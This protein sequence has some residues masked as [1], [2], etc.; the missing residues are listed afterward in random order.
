MD[1]ITNSLGIIPARFAS[2]RFPGKPLVD[3]GGKTMVQRVYEQACQ[4]VLGQVVVATD[5]Q[6]IFDHVASFGGQ[7]VMTSD[8]HPSGTDR[9]AE[10]AALPQYADFQFVVNVQ[11][12]EP[13]LSPAQI[14]LVLEVLASDE[15][16]PIA[17]LAK[18]IA[19][20]S[21]LD[22]LNPNM[23]KVV[24]DK[25]HRALYFS[26]WPLP[27]HRNIPRE[28]WPAN[29]IFYKHIG[30]Y[31]FRKNV[32]L[33]VAQLPPSRLE[34]AESLEQ[35]RWLENGYPIG[36]ALTE[37]ES[38][39]IDSPTDLELAVRQWAVGSQGADL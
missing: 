8:Q 13:F 21:K 11:G 18:Q 30:L 2:T 36:V 29:G 39:S 23:V 3:I 32:L 31:A 4:S 19:P 33:D 7:V 25:Q 35:L 24:F 5:D 16:C 14:N 17:T 15:N 37:T 22:L 38:I 20:D 28:E 26:R 34:L 12:D 27:F 6:R 9:C 10:V 1:K